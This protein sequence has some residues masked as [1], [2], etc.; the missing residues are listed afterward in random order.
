MSA[1]TPI[2]WV[3]ARWLN[4]WPLRYTVPAVLLIGILI[5]WFVP[6]ILTGE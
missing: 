1:F 4:R 6:L 3:I 2:A 5:A